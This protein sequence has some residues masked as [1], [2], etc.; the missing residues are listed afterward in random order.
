[1]SLSDPIAD[2]LTRIRNA[3]AAGLPKASVP[4]SRL[5]EEVLRVLL[6][7]GYLSS[8]AVRAEGARKYID[9]QLKYNKPNEPTIRGLRRVSKPGLRQYVTAKQVPKVLN[10]LGVSVLSTPSGV[11]PGTEAKRRGI[12]GE[13]LCTVW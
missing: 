11:M 12:G 3:G 9:V 5:K 7:E 4:H 2:L 1:M 13:V 8:Y 6:S 10:G